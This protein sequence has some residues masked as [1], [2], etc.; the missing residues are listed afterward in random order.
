MEKMPASPILGY[1]HDLLEYSDVQRT[2]RFYMILYYKNV[3]LRITVNLSVLLLHGYPSAFRSS[4]GH[5]MGAI[6]SSGVPQ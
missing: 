5:S 2:K 3:W 6:T 4:D 1:G